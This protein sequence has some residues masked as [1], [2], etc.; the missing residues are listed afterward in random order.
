MHD[1]WLRDNVQPHLHAPGSPSWAEPTS[2]AQQLRDF[3]VDDSNPEFWVYSG[4][5]DW[6]AIMSLFGRLMDCPQ[7]WPRSVRELRQLFE[8]YGIEKRE[9]PTQDN[10]HHYALA[11]ARWNLACWRYTQQQL[12]DA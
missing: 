8:F 7:P 3:T 12:K 4:A 11:D 6:V 5:Y 1:E 9:L 2:M 10:S